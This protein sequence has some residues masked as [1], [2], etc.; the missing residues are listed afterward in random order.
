L[1]AFTSVAAN[2]APIMGGILVFHD[3]IGIGA[4]AIVE[5]VITFGLVIAGTTFMPAPVR[6]H[7]EHALVPA[8]PVPRWELRRIWDCRP[9]TPQ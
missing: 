4:P 9:R 1:I 5:R 7:R 8:G 3:A 6:A 2:L